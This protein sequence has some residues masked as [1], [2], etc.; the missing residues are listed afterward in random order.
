MHFSTLASFNLKN[1]LPE[2]HLNLKFYSIQAIIIISI[3]VFKVQNFHSFRNQI[4]HVDFR[5]GC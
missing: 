3:F 5:F 2:G 4:H 1:R